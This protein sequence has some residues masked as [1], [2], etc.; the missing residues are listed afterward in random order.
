MNPVQT[1]N[2]LEIEFKWQFQ[3]SIRSKTHIF[4]AVGV[5][6]PF[7][8]SVMVTKLDVRA[9]MGNKNVNSGSSF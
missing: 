4:T 8:C 3:L 7:I 2:S 5:E 1:E 6:K 9:L